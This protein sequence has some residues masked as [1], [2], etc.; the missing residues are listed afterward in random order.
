MFIAAKATPANAS[1]KAPPRFN[2]LMPWNRFNKS[3]TPARQ[4]EQIYSFTAVVLQVDVDAKP[5]TGF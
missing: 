1:R 4:A 5:N 3:K 2:G